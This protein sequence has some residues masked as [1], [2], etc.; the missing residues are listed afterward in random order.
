MNH[1]PVEVDELR[2]ITLDQLLVACYP[3]IQQGLVR[4]GLSILAA[5]LSYE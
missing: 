2:L 5:Q 4:E 1:P 3:V